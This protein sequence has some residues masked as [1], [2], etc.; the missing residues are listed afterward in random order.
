MKTNVSLIN[1][2]PHFF[3]SYTVPGHL[4]LHLNGKKQKS[5]ELRNY[6][7]E[8]QDW[9]GFNKSGTRRGSEGA[10][11]SIL[12]HVVGNK[13]IKQRPCRA[14]VKLSLEGENI[15]QNDHSCQVP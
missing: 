3:F 15:G 9:R 4:G 7:H 5:K 12:D 8:E 13:F 6:C 10:M 1:C 14:Y 2:L 11:P